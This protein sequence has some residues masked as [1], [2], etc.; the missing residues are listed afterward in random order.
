MLTGIW[1]GA[2][3]QFIVWGA[4]HGFF[5]ILE[6]GKFGELLNKLPNII[7]RI[8]TLLIVVVGWVFFRAESLGKA[9]FY[10]KNM[11]VI[12]LQGVA[13]VTIVMEFTNMFLVM[14]AVAI[15]ASTPLF[16]KIGAAKLFNIEW[17]NRACYLVLWFISV[18]YMV[19]LS[20][21]PF[22]YFQF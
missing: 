17:L 8:Y 10:L 7:K 21:N 16:Q 15:L 11:F 20:Y 18:I 5:L 1:H 3:W 4:I 9:V 19:G 13:N 22:I 12:N 2:A 6:R 14:S